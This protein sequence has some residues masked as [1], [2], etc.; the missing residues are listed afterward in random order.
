LLFSLPVCS[1]TLEGLDAHHDVPSIRFDISI[2]DSGKAGKSV[3]P[4][5]PVK[6]LRPPSIHGKGCV[7]QDSLIGADGGDRRRGWSGWIPPARNHFRPINR[8]AL[9]ISMMHI[10]TALT[11]WRGGDAALDRQP[12]WSPPS[13]RGFEGSTSQS[14][15]YISIFNLWLRIAVCDPIRS[16]VHSHG[17]GAYPKEVDGHG[18]GVLFDSS[19][20]LL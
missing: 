16:F 9:E 5:V 3:S 17:H 20:G 13:G 6:T 11:N 19:L 7:E 10:W 14:D 15:C 4:I 1:R 12:P 18:G 2:I 8:S